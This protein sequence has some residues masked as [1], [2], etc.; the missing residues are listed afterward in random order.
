M[1]DLLYDCLRIRRIEEAICDAYPQLKMRCP[2]HISIGQEAVAVGV[3]SNLL[4][5]DKVFSGHRAHAHYLAKQG[6]LKKFIAELHGLESGCGMGRSGSMH[7]QDVEAG[8]IASTSIVGGTLGLA[9]GC[10]W[11][12]KIKGDNSVTVVFFGDGCAEEG[13]LHEVL[14]FS[15]LHRLAIVFVCENNGLAVT[16][17][18]LERQN[19]H[20]ISE[21][22]RAHGLHS[23]F[24]MFSDVEGI[25]DL[26][27][28]AISNARQ[29]RPQFLEFL[30]ERQRTH[31]GVDHEFELQN[32]CIKD[33]V[34]DES[35]IQK[36][37]EEAFEF[38][39]SSK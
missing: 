5:T 38:A 10:A 27:A 18:L 33:Y 31:V 17:P 1:S 4:K 36:E 14:N 13:V 15:S 9:T 11:A 16:T 23:E 28:H 3:C 39:R 8:F 19:N 7:L 6:D 12:S 34:V 35:E 24:Y 21:I 20:G 37:I 32:D 29:G 25:S 22:A 30:T 26:A 2:T